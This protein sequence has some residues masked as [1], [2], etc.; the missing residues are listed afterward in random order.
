MIENLI[1][2]PPQIR[3][4]VLINYEA[5]CEDDLSVQYMKIIKINNQLK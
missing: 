1:V 4:Y 5:K 3:P 2:P